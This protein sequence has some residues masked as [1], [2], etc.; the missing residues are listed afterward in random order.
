MAS[1]TQEVKLILEGL[2]SIASKSLQKIDLQEIFHVIQELGKGGYGSVLMVKDKKTDQKMALKVMDKKKT[3]K[4]CFLKE[5]SM[6]FFLSSHPNIIET[7]G[8]AFK[9]ADSFAFSQELAVAGDLFSLIPPNDGLPED[10]VKRCAVQ[11]SSALD[12]ID[13]KGLVHLDIKPEN[14]LV[15]DKDCHCVKLTDFG[16]S[17]LKGTVTKVRSGS[18]SYMAPEM[19]QLINQDTLLVDSTLDVWS[20]GIV[21]YCLLTGDFPWQSAVS[22]DK[23]YNCFVEWQNNFESLELPAPWRRLSPGVVKMFHG[24]L[25]IDCKKRDKSTGVLMFL[26]EYW[27]EQISESTEGTLGHADTSKVNLSEESARIATDASVSSVSTTSLLSAMSCYLTSDSFESEREELPKDLKDNVLNP[28]IHI[29]D[30]ISVHVGAEV[31]IG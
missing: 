14:I 16:L 28:P 2:V 30:E 13:R 5:F 10:I 27:K 12:F 1:S 20:F 22:T 23:D 21:L 25:A 9:T 31:E 26:G 4:L 18:I 8:I 6:S 24:L 3:S 19:S 17:R 11:I 15:F 29:D 7:Y